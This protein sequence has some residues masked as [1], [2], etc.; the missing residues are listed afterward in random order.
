[1]KRYDHIPDVRDGLTRI[2]RA[3][4]V[5]LHEFQ[6]KNGGRDVPTILLW[7]E[8]IDRGYDISQDQLNVILG[9][10][11]GMKYPGAQTDE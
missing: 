5:C 9:R 3:V 4:L 6:Q 2:E 7:G 11:G 1:L 8:L 10:L